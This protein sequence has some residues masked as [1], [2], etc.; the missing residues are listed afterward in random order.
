MEQSIKDDPV[1]GGGHANGG[2]R[3]PLAPDG[4]PPPAPPAPA[5][6]RV[7][8]YGEIIPLLKSSAQIVSAAL[9]TNDKPYF[10]LQTLAMC[11]NAL[12]NGAKI[13]LAKRRIDVAEKRLGKG[14]AIS[15]ETRDALKELSEINRDAA[16]PAPLKKKLNQALEA[17]KHQEMTEE[18]VLD[19][20]AANEDSDLAGLEEG[21]RRGRIRS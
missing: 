6:P 2:L 11:I 8:L 14:G 13:D 4:T 12:Q 10:A 21:Q 3:S 16:L 1:S 5:S 17:M 15:Q 7:E 20:L 18:Q 19:D 9:R